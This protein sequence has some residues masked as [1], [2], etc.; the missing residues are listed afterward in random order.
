MA[1][2]DGGRA[3]GRDADD[4]PVAGSDLDTG[5]ADELYVVRLR[6]LV[7]DFRIG[8]HPHERDG[9]QRVRV[10]VTVDA[11]RPDGGFREDY[12]RVYCYERLAAGIR[13]LAGGGHIGLVE[14]LAERIA[15]LAMADPR[16]RRAEVTVDKLDV[17]PDAEGA[18]VTVTR[19]RAG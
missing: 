9:A 4:R 17:F 19:R 6:G 16:A 1:P 13:A 14:T 5:V 15:E 18:G 7:V 11:V 3:Y 2:D 8:I 12:R 10:D